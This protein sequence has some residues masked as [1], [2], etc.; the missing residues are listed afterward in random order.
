MSVPVRLLKAA[1]HTF[2]SV[3]KHWTPA[4]ITLT[5]V[6]TPARVSRRNFRSQQNHCVGGLLCH[7]CI[8]QTLLHT[9]QAERCH[10][11]K[12]GIAA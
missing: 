10:D 4:L 8:P 11:V 6:A 2:Q 12:P 1:Q 5:M 3:I 9:S 7:C